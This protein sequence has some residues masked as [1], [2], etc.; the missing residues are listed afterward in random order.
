LT[1]VKKVHAIIGGFH[2]TD[3]N[4]ATVGATINDLIEIDPDFI[5][6]CHCTG[7]KPKRRLIDAFQQKCNPLITGDTFKV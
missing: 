1:G 7:L 4:E 2:L 3:S 6:P 5:Y